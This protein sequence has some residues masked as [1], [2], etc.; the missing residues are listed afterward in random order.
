LKIRR[1][2]PG[3]R[4]EASSLRKAALSVLYQR[5]LI[6]WWILQSVVAQQD[7]WPLQPYPLLTLPAGS[8]VGTV[9]RVTTLYD[10]CVTQ[11]GLSAMP[12]GHRTYLKGKP[13]GESSMFE[14]AEYGEPAYPYVCLGPDGKVKARLLEPQCPFSKNNLIG[15][16]G[17]NTPM[18]RDVRGNGDLKVQLAAR[19]PCHYQPSKGQ[20]DD[21]CTPYLIQMEEDR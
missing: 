2:T 19:N 8:V 14:T 10:P 5:K 13:G 15:Y 11:E 4:V 3:D 1:M 9:R 20:S 21:S 7:G 16:S 6:A 18:K 17:T 12:L